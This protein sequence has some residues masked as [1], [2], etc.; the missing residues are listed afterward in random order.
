MPQENHTH[1]HIVCSTHIQKSLIKLWLRVG[2]GI[3]I[4]IVLEY[5][6]QL[7]SAQRLKDRKN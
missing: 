6:Q 2:G 1:T 5:G 7:I 4:I 3:P